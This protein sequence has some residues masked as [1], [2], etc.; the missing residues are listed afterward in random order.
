MNSKQLSN[1]LLKILGL[2]ISLRTI[3]SLFTAIPM[4]LIPLSFTTTGPLSTQDRFFHQAVASAV[5]VAASAAI[6]IGIGILLIVQ[7]QKISD[8][9]FKNETE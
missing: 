3:P 6:E 2:S 9:L 8:F 7:S 1:V 5:G 4:V